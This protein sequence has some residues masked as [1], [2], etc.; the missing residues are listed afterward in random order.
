MLVTGA[1]SANRKLFTDDVQSILRAKRPII[2]TAIANVITASDLL[3]R[4]LTLVLPTIALNS[5]KASSRLSQQ[6]RQ[7]GVP[8]ANLRFYPRR[9]GRRT[10]RTCRRAT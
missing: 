3:D 1:A 6:L 5:G 9:S 2:V 4:T 10:G 7:E 8:R